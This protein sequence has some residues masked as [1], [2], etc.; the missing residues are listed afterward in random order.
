[1]RLERISGVCT[2]CNEEER[3][4]LP[5]LDNVGL[6]RNPML[7]DCRLPYI[8]MDCLKYNK[9]VMVD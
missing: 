5:N 9:I 3:K 7:G 4:E 2:L 8:S 6:P 1:M